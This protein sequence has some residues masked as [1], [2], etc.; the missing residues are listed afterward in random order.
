MDGGVKIVGKP[1]DDGIGAAG[2]Y[3]A[4]VV[5]DFFQA[6]SAEPRVVVLDAAAPKFELKDGVEC[7]PA[8]S[9]VAGE[10]LR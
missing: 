7:D 9:E 4:D 3:S 10:A 2:K 1:S 8:F 6:G 5:Q